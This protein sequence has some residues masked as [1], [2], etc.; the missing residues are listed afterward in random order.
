MRR[1]LI[2]AIPPGAPHADGG[3]PA[4]FQAF[5]AFFANARPASGPSTAQDSGL[6]TK[7][8]SIA[9]FSDLRVASFGALTIIAASGLS[10]GTAT[11]HQ[12]AAPAPAV[13]TSTSTDTATS[14]ADLLPAAPPAVAVTADN[15]TPPA[16]LDE[17]IAAQRADAAVD[18]QLRC[19]ATAIYFEAGHE[20]HRGQLAVGRVIVARSKSGRFPA[21][22]CG[23]VTQHS[24][25]SFVHGGTLPAVE[26]A[27]RTWRDSLAV[28]RIADAGSWKSPVEGALFFHAVRVSPAWHAQRL[29]RVDNQIFYR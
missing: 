1:R 19:L 15:S 29:A 22:Y 2:R 9:R 20:T 16:S 26:T 7:S 13:A 10:G 5:A 27:S 21:S 8:F 17:L 24:Q 25:F 3:R 18:S 12:P 14:S 28:A 6:M 23:V 11:A 4:G